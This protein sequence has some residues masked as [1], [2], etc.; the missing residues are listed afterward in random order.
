MMLCLYYNQDLKTKNVFS[1]RRTFSF[2]NG[3]A[4]SWHACPKKEIGNIVI[5]SRLI[6]KCAAQKF[7]NVCSSSLWT[8]YGHIMKQN[9]NSDFFMISAWLCLFEVRRSL[10][11]RWH[12]RGKRAVKEL[13]TLVWQFWQIYLPVVMAPQMHRELRRYPANTRHLT[14]VGPAS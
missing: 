1:F 9:K 2:L 4:F 3:I 7:K 11:V 12:L 10:P 14:N 13:I 8:S 5:I 6:G